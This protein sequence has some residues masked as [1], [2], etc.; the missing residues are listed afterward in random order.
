[1]IGLSP[2]GFLQ[3]LGGR[4]RGEV[5]EEAPSQEKRFMSIKSDM[6]RKGLLL[7]DTNWCLEPKLPYRCQIGV[8]PIPAPAVTHCQYLE[9][10]LG[11]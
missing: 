2:Q 4:F 5:S 9:Q 3:M 10:P 11:T 1:M 8:S 7:S 6:Q